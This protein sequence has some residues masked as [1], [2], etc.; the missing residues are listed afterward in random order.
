MGL[1]E[2]AAQ[3]K[4]LHDETTKAARIAASM[5]AWEVKV[6]AAAV[7]WANAVGQDAEFFFPAGD[8]DPHYKEK[9]VVAVCDGWSFY[10][11][12]KDM[13]ASNSYT[14]HD[15]DHAAYLIREMERWTH[16][17]E[18]GKPWAIRLWTPPSYHADAPK[19]RSLADLG[20]VLLDYQADDRYD[21]KPPDPETLIWR[22]V[23]WG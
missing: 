4:A 23:K 13:R 6:N 14:S 15:N 12:D 19:I 1:L 10:V 20:R 16:S 17:S 18:P 3:A 11:T 9:G 21:G 2:N 5:A 22:K 8:H 7:F